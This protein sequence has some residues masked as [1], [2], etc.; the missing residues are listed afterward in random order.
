MNTTNH[1][2]MSH[3]TYHWKL[4]PYN[5]LTQP[6]PC[7]LTDAT[8]HVRTHAMLCEIAVADAPMHRCNHIMQ[9]IERKVR[10]LI[11]DLC[12]GSPGCLLTASSTAILV[13]SEAHSGMGRLRSLAY[14]FCRAGEVP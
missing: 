1:E 2:Y 7:P 14:P 3:V 5:N 9:K 11:A 12:V 6:T 10:F 8:N 13:D 4:Y